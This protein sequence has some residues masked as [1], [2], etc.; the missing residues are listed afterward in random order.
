[1][2][3]RR[4]F[5]RGASGDD[6]AGRTDVDGVDGG[7]RGFDLGAFDDGGGLGRDAL[8]R[9]PRAGGDRGHAHRI[10]PHGGAELSGLWTRL[11]LLP[12]LAC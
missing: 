9:S 1:M 8:G 3:D 5:D 6:G 12:S 10:G 11:I 7:G 4:T 2:D